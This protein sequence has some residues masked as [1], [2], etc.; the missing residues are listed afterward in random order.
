MPV[1]GGTCVLYR[2]LTVYQHRE[3]A[4]PNR[5]RAHHHH[6]AHHNDAAGTTMSPESRTPLERAL[7]ES[8]EL[9]LL[10]FKTF[11]TLSTYASGFSDGGV[12]AR[13]TLDMLHHRMYLGGTHDHDHHDDDERSTSSADVATRR[14]S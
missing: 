12:Q 2:A 10:L 8:S 9:K 11:A 14:V 4:M 1:D 5:T 6:E 3:T 7:T 13:K